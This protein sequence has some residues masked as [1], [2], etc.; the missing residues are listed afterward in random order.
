MAKPNDEVDVT[1]LL[2]IHG[3][4][5]RCMPPLDERVLTVPDAVVWLRD[6]FEP[7]PVRLPLVEELP[8]H[9]IPLKD[10]IFDSLR[11]GYPG[12]DKWWREKCVADHRPCWVVYIGRQIAGIVVR[13]EET[14]AEAGTRHPGPK[15]LKVCTFKVKP[16]FRGEKLGELLLKQ[17]LWFAQ[18]N[19]FDLFI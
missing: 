10:D 19:A 15:I 8:A 6:A 5:R 1:L 2:G 3:R 12:F 4:A 9:A 13:K 18:I 11:D 17:I 16:E 14:H 7:R